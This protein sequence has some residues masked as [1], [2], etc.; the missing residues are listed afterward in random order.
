MYWFLSYNNLNQSYIY[1]CPLPLEC[2]SHLP[3]HP[4]PLSCKRSPGWVPCVVQQISPGYLF[5][6]W[7]CIYF[8]A[9]LSIHPTLSFPP[10]QVC[11]LC[12]RLYC[13]PTN[14]FI[15]TIFL[16]IVIFFLSSKGRNCE[17]RDSVCCIQCVFSASST[18]SGT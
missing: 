5:Y 3:P 2:P 12:L 8:N 16:R 18:R 4:I 17:F 10:C 1:I 14:R 9:T 7:Q 6:I 15:S 13:C 11:S